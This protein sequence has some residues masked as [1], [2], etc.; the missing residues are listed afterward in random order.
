MMIWGWAALTARTGRS[1][2]PLLFMQVDWS[3]GAVG[4]SQRGRALAEPTSNSSSDLTF[5]RSGPN[6]LIRIVCGQQ[7]HQ[8]NQ[9]VVVPSF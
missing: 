9:P 5:S 7:R 6:I 2:L 3:G 4:G 1:G 8:V